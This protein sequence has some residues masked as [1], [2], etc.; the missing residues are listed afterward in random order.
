MIEQDFLNLLLQ[1]SFKTFTVCSSL[2]LL[3]LDLTQERKSRENG[4]LST[5][6]CLWVFKLIRYVNWDLERVETASCWI[7]LTFEHTR[8]LAKSVSLFG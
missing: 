3:S 7:N 5:F 6:R 2:T 4:I 1:H 8:A